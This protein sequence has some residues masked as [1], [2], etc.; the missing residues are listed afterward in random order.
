MAAAALSPRAVRAVNCPSCGA[1]IVL[2]GLAWT[3]TV[4]CA[5][6]GAVLDASDPNL[7]ILQRARERMTVEPLIPLGTRGQ[8]RGAPYEVIGFQQRTIRADDVDYSRHE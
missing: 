6:C 5:S 2:R 4:A 1:A 7:A 3:R 8:W